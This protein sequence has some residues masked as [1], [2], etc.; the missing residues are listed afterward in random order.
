MTLFTRLQSS[1]RNPALSRV[2]RNRRHN[3][4]TAASRAAI[5]LHH[6]ERFEDRSLLS[7][8]GTLV[9]LPVSV[10]K[11]PSKGES[12]G[13]LQ[14]S[15]S[16]PQLNA[17]VDF[18]LFD[19]VSA[20][21]LPG[22]WT[23]TTTNSNNWITVAS[24]S[25]TAPNHAFVA[26][27]GDVSDNR[28]T[29]PSFAVSP[30]N[31]RLSFRNFYD[32]ES[33]FDGGVL[34]IS[35][36]G[37][38]FTDIITAGGTFV[39]NG[40]VSVLSTG[41]SN[42]LGGRNAWHGNS[43]GYLTTVVDLP[44]AAYGENA[45][46]RW[47]MGT[48]DSVT[49]TGW[50]VDTIQL[51]D[52]PAPPTE[53]FGDA[54][55]P[56]P[57]TIAENGARHTVGALFLGATVDAEADGTHSSSA[58]FDGGD[59]GVA[60]TTGLDP[61]QTETVQVTASLGGGVLNA[62]IDWNA[63]GDWTDSGE[64]I[65]TDQPLSAGVNSLSVVVPPG[66]TLGQSFARFRISTATGTGITGAAADG[67]VEDHAVN[68]GLKRFNWVNRGLASDRFDSTF[69]ANAAL[70]RGVVDAVFTSWERAITDLN[71]ASFGGPG[72][73]NITVSMAAS[74][75]GF[76][77]S[78]GASFQNGYPTSGNVTISRGND[79]TGDGVGDGAGFFLD[80]TPLDWSEFQGNPTGGAFTVSAQAGSPAAGMSDLFTLV[81]AEI[82]HAIGLFLNP[83]RINN[84]NNGT[85]TD[86][87]ITDD[88][89]GG[90][91]GNYWVFDGPSV[92]HL[93]TSNNGGPGGNDFGQVVHTA[94][95]P[96]GAPNQPLTFNSAFRG[97]RDL[98]GADDP[99]NAIYNFSQRTL[100]NDVLAL[101]FQDA[102]DYSITLPQTFGT[103]Y[104]FMDEANSELII[105]G[106]LGG[107][108]DDFEVSLD[109]TDVV[110]SVDIGNDIAGTG[111]NGDASDIAAFVS[112]FPIA[113]ISTITINAGDGDDTI[114]VAPQ[115]GIPITINGGTPAFPNGGV[116]DELSFDVTGVT[117]VV[118]TDNGNGTG[119]L[120]SSSHGTVTWSEIEVVN[121]PLAAPL[122]VTAVR[123][124]GSGWTSNF[125]DAADGESVGSGLGVGY[126]I[127]TGSAAQTAV[128]PWSSFNQLVV[129]FTE[130]ID[131]GTVSANGNVILHGMLSSP[132]ISSIS[133]TDNVMTINLTGNLTVDSLRLEIQDSVLSTAG[134]PLDGDFTNEVSMTSGGP[135]PV[136]DPLNN[137]NFHLAT[138]P[139]DADRS[140][141]VNISDAII[142]FQNFF[143]T[144]GDAGYTI[145]ADMTGDGILN[146]S[147]AIVVFQNFFASPPAGFPGL[148][149][150]DNGASG[151]APHAP[152]QSE[153]SD[154]V[155][156]PPASVR[157]SSGSSATEPVVASTRTVSGQ[158]VD[159]DQQPDTE[160]QVLDDVLADSVGEI[161]AH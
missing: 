113:A 131:A 110:V 73:I 86:T 45:Q 52:V 13:F 83:A 1:V 8:V 150:A 49:A 50:R 153:P 66:A 6:I 68:I 136:G 15:D 60:F 75:T 82:T 12:D 102:Y 20:P 41:F 140:G 53:D 101:V 39:S 154:V 137:F 70:A 64:Q 100:V 57:V 34:E 98:V 95:K 147:D 10:S 122:Q 7:G 144:P 93:M 96:G 125:R 54:P 133:V 149:A 141:T 3:R 21:A 94:G 152:T 11:L 5:G 90:G 134:E 71:H 9:D 62:W 28:L 123:A 24:G 106:G 156:P 78:A 105:R 30:A 59:D 88:S 69:G 130:N 158:Q 44:T 139:G 85:V 63:D 142:I 67:E 84:P 18:E 103:A 161:L 124:V 99:G 112:R 129:S 87:G 29:S 120:T 109:G 35:I 2:S 14:G 114:L 118:F 159:T 135:A 58:A 115:I 38:A 92:T 138:N 33:G 160:L 132:N 97:S 19:G 76:G 128:L 157:P 77:A 4:R 40:Y 32:T 146:I 65:F 126:H 143:A 26:N 46:L 17:T 79:T 55:A 111:P 117:G 89:E 108:N 42:P 74:G 107:S 61:G 56:Y 72:Q 91:L 31:G 80:P 119:S 48:D 36:N 22:G 47:R 151:T 104:A 25:D 145:F 81:N 155:G 37:G 23:S 121:A 51:S 127:P 27:I 16:G 43:G 148:F 116:G